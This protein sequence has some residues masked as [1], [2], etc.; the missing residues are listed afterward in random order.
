MTGEDTG[1]VVE[2]A[3]RRDQLWPRV[4]QGVVYVLA[5]SLVVTFTV[6]L[7]RTQTVFIQVAPEDAWPVIVTGVAFVAVGTVLLERGQRVNGA[8]LVTFGVLFSIN[9]LNPVMRSTP[10]ALLI[11]FSFVLLWL[12]LAWVLLRYPDTRI[13]RWYER[14][15]LVVAAVWQLGWQGLVTITWPPLWADGEQ[16]AHWPELLPSYQLHAFALRAVEWGNV[17]L[18]VGLIVLMILR[19]R[20]TSGLDRAT[21]GPTYVAAGAMAIAGFA[22]GMSTA[23]RPD[24]EVPQRAPYLLLELLALLVIPFVL[25]YGVV[26]RRL[27]RSRVADLVM[28]VNSAVAP[29]EVEAALRR[30]MADPGLTV[31]FWSADLDGYVDVRGQSV[32]DGPPPG[33][34]RYPVTTRSGEPLAVVHADVSAAHHHEL[35]DAALAAS[36]LALENAALHASLLARLA[37]VRES[38]ARLAG[39]ATVERRRIERDLH[40]GAQQGLLALGLTLGRAQA[41]G[42]SAATAGLLAQARGELTD[43]LQQLRRLASGLHPAVL[44]QLG[45]GSALEVVAERFPIPVSLAVPDRRWPEPV[46]TTAYFVAC[47]ALA[48]AVKHSQATHLRVEVA[49]RADR[50]ILTVADNGRGG[51][52]PVVGHGLV[53]MRDRA[54]AL[55]GTV[56]ITSQ[57]DSGTLIVAELPCV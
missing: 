16:V 4:R 29:A 52:H 33:R 9:W 45:L 48:N 44:T 57:Q 34:V 49:D 56:T 39:A 21:Y 1:R 13:A 18:V 26:R 42:D 20:R 8:L 30:T 47:E 19:A 7:I 3:A 12:C 17:A 41:A 6:A 2:T 10:V 38:R 5:V 53:G 15:F 35:L 50:L 27:V 43:A 54:A 24:L 11:Q 55:G 36:S 51:A 32:V 25:L 23:G 46:E 31:L 14:V 22:N 37:E 40:D 28:R